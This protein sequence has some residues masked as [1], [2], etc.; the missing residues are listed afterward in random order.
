MELTW[1]HYRISLVPFMLDPWEQV[2]YILGICVLMYGVFH[3]LSRCLSLWAVATDRVAVVV[4]S[5]VDHM[6]KSY[7][8]AKGVNGHG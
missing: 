6:M 4:N 7:V 3:A 8:A 2:L 1:H 5:W